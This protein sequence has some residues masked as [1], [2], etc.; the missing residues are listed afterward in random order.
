MSIRVMIST[1]SQQPSAELG[2]RAVLARWTQPDD[3]PDDARAARAAVERSAAAIRRWNGSAAGLLTMW[4]GLMI[5]RRPGDGVFPHFYRRTADVARELGC[6]ITY[7][8]CSEFED[9]VYMDTTFGMRPAAWSYANDLLGPNVLVIGGAAA[10]PDELRLLAETGTPLAHSP[11]ANMKMATGIFPL[12]DAL[13][14]GVP[15]SLGTDG[16]LNNNVHDMFAE[17]K[18]SVLLHNAVRRRAT[19]VSPQ[20]MLELATLG[21]AQAIGRAHELGSLEPGKLADIVLVRLDR[22][23]TLPVHDIV[24][25]LV[26]AANGGDVDTVMIGGRVVLRGGALVYEDEAGILTAATGAAARLRAQLG[27]RTA[28]GWPIE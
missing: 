11:V 1:H 18:S 6:G 15:V 26:F 28:D 21:G 8:F 13:A 17:M 12:P 2:I 24:S 16:G 27:L 14:A 3:G 7:H 9:S 5:P 22:A 10:T 4:F 25:N 23:H 20:T 19:T